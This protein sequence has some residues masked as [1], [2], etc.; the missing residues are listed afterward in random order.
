MSDHD[1]VLDDSVLEMPVLDNPK[2]QPIAYDTSRSV[3]LKQMPQYLDD[4]RH[5]DPQGSI[6][7]LYARKNKYKRTAYK[8]F[9]RANQ[10]EAQIKTLEHRIGKFKLKFGREK[11]T[12]KWW[13]NAFWILM[14]ILIGLLFAALTIS[15]LPKG[16]EVKKANDFPL[17]RPSSVPD[18]ED[19]H[20]PKGG[21]QPKPSGRQE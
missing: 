10:A 1:S 11:A 21:K 4:M 18:L 7:Y 2:P 19:H 17:T 12:A 9:D 14:G 6:D 15:L 5:T 16:S 8:E 20:P 3:M 13:K